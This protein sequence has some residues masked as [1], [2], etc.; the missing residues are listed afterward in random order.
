MRRP[1]RASASIAALKGVQRSAGAGRVLDTPETLRLVLGRVQ[2]TATPPC[3]I[4]TDPPPFAGEPIAAQHGSPGQPKDS[5]PPP[6]L[7]LEPARSPS[8]E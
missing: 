2:L 1:L 3:I 8:V 5:A 7:S 6:Q 4:V